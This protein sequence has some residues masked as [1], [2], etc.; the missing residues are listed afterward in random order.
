MRNVSTSRAR[1]QDTQRGL[2][3][4]SEPTVCSMKQPTKQ[5]SGKRGATHRRRDRE[6][7]RA[8]DRATGPESSDR[9]RRSRRTIPV[10]DPRPGRQFTT[11]FD[12]A[13]ADAGITAVTIPPPSPRANA[14]A[15]RFVPTIRTDVTD[16]ILIFGEQHLRTVLTEHARHDNR[17]RPHLRAPTPPTPARPTDR[18]Y[19]HGT[20][21]TPIRPRRPDQRIPTSRLK[22]QVNPRWP[23]SG[24]PQAARS[25][26]ERAALG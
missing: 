25:A 23:S 6:P 20:D 7:R 15:Q 8:L 14:S 18:R 16:R 19:P 22:D 13:L 4:V 12:A 2:R 9:S 21:H 26:A 5:L 17:R 11:S 3:R 1:V 24:T 10:S